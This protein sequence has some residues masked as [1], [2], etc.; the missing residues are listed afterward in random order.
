MVLN[1]MTLKISSVRLLVAIT[2]IFIFDIWY[3][4]INQS[5][6]QSKSEIKRNIFIKPNILELGQ[7]QLIQV[8]KIFDG[9]VESI[10]YCNE[11]HFEHHIEHL[12]M[13]EIEGYF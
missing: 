8:V 4:D 1:P 13:N 3:S 11:A 2:S 9:L 5:Y 6:L 12:P 10:D 7:K